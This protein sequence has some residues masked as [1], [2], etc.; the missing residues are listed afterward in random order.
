MYLEHCN[1]YQVAFEARLKLVIDKTNGNLM[2]LQLEG[3]T[4]SNRDAKPMGMIQYWLN[5]LPNSDHA[6]HMWKYDMSHKQRK[7]CKE[8]LDDFVRGYMKHITAFGDSQRKQASRYVL[9]YKPRDYKTERQEPYDYKAGRK[10]S[11]YKRG[12]AVRGFKRVKKVFGS[13]LNAVEEHEDL[14]LD[15]DDQEYE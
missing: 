15:F 5:G 13:R 1:A 9:A 3:G 12:E 14:E 8:S 4:G 11:D 10:D 2:P 6:Y 7:K